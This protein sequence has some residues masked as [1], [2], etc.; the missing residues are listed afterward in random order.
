MKKRSTELKRKET[1]KNSSAYGVEMRTSILEYISNFYQENDC[2]PS[3]KEL[4]E[5]LQIKSLVCV[6]SH[7]HKLET[8]GL[9][10]LEN[11]KIKYSCAVK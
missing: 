4:A 10:R 2:G 3:I 8:E 11:G 9:L 5:E 1:R 7:V 6:Y